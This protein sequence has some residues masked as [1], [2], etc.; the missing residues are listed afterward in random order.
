MTTLHTLLFVL[1]VLIAVALIGFILIQQGKGADAGAAFGGGSSGTVF[2]SQGS[3][4]FMVKVTSVLA[5]IFLANSLF[6]GYLASQSVQTAP[7][8]LMDR[9]TVEEVAE[10]QLSVEE[11]M[12]AMSEEFGDGDLPSLPTE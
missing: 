9:V 4:G 5:T 12:P 11:D 1:Q 8:S 3:G 7:E 10:E 2:G 6:L